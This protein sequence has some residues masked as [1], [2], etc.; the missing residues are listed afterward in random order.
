M[1][2]TELTA[3]LGIIT[4]ILFE[5]VP[6]FT[7]WYQPKSDVFKRLF[8]AGLLLIIAAGAVLGSC[9]LNFTW[10]ECSSAGIVETLLAVLTAAGIG[11]AANQGTH[12][13]LKRA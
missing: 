5:Y 7:T 3:V 1:S 10:L 6:G 11:V 13:V 12:M 8:M 2:P 9:Y 4:Q